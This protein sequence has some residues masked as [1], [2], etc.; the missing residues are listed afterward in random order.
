[1]NQAPAATREAPKPKPREVPSEELL[2][3][4]RELR[5]RHQGACYVLRL[6]RQDKLILTK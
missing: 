4:E 5:I 6:T 3:G 2:R 1:M